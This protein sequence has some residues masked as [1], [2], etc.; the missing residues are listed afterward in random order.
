MNLRAAKELPATDRSFEN[1][2]LVELLAGLAETPPG[3]L[4]A[5]TTTESSVPEALERWSR[6]TGNAIVERHD[7]AAQIRWLVRRGRAPSVTDGDRALGTRVWLYTNF[8]CN[9]ACSYCC[10]RSSPKAARRELGLDTVRRICREAVPLGV[11]EVFVTGGE[12]FLLRD[13]SA[14]LTACTELAPTTLLTNGMLLTRRRLQE[15][16]SLP[17][18]RLTLQISIDSAT[19]EL[20]D[21]QRGAGSWVRAM[22]GVAAARATDLRVRL[23]ATLDADLGE[24]ELLELAARHGIPARDVIVRRVARRGFASS[25]VALVRSDLMPEITITDSGVYWHPVGA[26]DADLLVSSEIFPLDRAFARVREAYEREL[27]FD[28][29]LMQIF[30]CA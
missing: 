18:D 24:Q 5:F 10:V 13:I 3:E 20:H 12:P 28:R 17:A 25:G 9:L 21:R 1:G 26:D 15:L 27:A 8:H 19:P 22:R 14:I 2:L 6:I 29:S 23:A 11:R 16:R 4:L 30:R 7:G